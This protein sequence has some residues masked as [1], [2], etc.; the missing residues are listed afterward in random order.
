M[1]IVTKKDIVRNDHQ[2]LFLIYLHK[3]KGITF[4]EEGDKEQSIRDI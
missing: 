4:T 2:E 1:S 3:L